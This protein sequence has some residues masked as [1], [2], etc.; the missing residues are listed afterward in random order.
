MKIVKQVKANSASSGEGY[1]TYQFDIQ[2]KRTQSVE[3]MFYQIEQTADGCGTNHHSGVT[4]SRTTTN[5][6]NQDIR[7][8]SIKVKPVTPTSNPIWKK[9]KQRSPNARFTWDA[10]QTKVSFRISEGFLQKALLLVYITG[11]EKFLTF[12]PPNLYFEKLR[13]E[14]EGAYRDSFGPL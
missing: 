1:I 14:V 8:F 2:R 3:N 12:T 10:C 6:Q 9:A 11:W 4:I 5:H 7:N 13:Q